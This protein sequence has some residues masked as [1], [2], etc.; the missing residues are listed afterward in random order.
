MEGRILTVVAPCAVSVIEGLRIRDGV[1]LRTPVVLLIFNRVEPTKQV[2]ARIAQARPK[3]LFIVA[4][5]PRTDVPEDR[6]RCLEVRRVV[7]KIDWDCSVHRNY[8]DPNLGLKERVAS[9]LDWVFDQVEEAIIL[10][11]DCLPDPTFFPFCEKLLEEFEQD[12]RVMMIAG[13]NYLLDRLQIEDSFLFSRY[14]SIWGWA[15]W[16]RAWKKYDR[17]LTDWSDLKKRKIL[18]AMYPQR[19]FR[20]RL[21]NWFDLAQSGQIETWDIQWFY[22]CLFNNG[23]CIVPRVNLVS[24]IGDEGTHA[25]RDRKNIGLPTFSLDLESIQRPRFV[26]PSQE[27]DATLIRQRFLLQRPRRILRRVLE[28]VGLAL[29]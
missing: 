3:V 13:T 8:S 14:F 29:A 4:D 21:S 28:E 18:K 23:L 1:M 7:E 11:D 26:V 15:T 2:F 16:A 10:E 9:G 27:Y 12:E 24:N 19:Y 20:R 22:S 5:G 6:E 25:S 17:S